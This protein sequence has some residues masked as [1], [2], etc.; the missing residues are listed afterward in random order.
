MPGAWV[1]HLGSGGELEGA[2]RIAG[3]AAGGADVEQLVLFGH[4][5]VEV[6]H[7]IG[8]V[9]E[10]TE[11]LGGAG[12]RG[13][14]THDLVGIGDAVRVGV[15]RHA[16]DALH[17]RVV[18]HKA[19]HLVHVRSLLGH[20]HGDH[21]DAEGLGHAEVAIVSGNG[22]QPLDLFQPAPRLRPQRAEVPAAGHRLV[23]EGQ[24]GIAAHD[25][26]FGLVVQHGRHEA[27]RFG[28]PSSTP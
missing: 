14:A 13:Q 9:P 16:P 26:V 4:V 20:G 7:A 25:D 24:A 21:L 22:A 12:H 17:G 3:L 28:Q 27:L 15:F 1:R 10:D 19:L 23:H 2:V 18:A 5:V 11:V 6:M 8:V